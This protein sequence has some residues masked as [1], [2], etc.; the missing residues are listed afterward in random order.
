MSYCHQMHDACYGIVGL[1]Y[2]YTG[3]SIL[4]AQVFSARRPVDLH[5]HTFVNQDM[6]TSESLDN[7][8]I[9]PVIMS[10]HCGNV[11]LVSG[12]LMSTVAYQFLR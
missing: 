7:D 12:S 3:V 8:V 1:V 6:I 9:L 2:V 10:R 4:I 5:I 11:S